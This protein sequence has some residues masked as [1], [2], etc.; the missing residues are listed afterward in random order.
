MDC[1]KL[2]P[3]LKSPYFFVRL[4]HFALLTLNDEGNKIV[5]FPS[6]GKALL[7]KNEML[8]N[9][10][11]A[12]RLVSNFKSDVKTPGLMYVD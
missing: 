10:T 1:V 5:S 8:T 9:P 2:T 12:P 11:F 6:F 7:P 4:V 3:R